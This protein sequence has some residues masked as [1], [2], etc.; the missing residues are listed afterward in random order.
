MN[1]SSWI[2][3]Q[4]YRHWIL[5]I[6]L[7][8]LC[9]K[10]KQVQL[11]MLNNQTLCTESVQH[12]K[13]RAALL[14]GCSQI[15]DTIFWQ[16]VL[17]KFEKRKKKPSDAVARGYCPQTA[18]LQKHVP[19]KVENNWVVSVDLLFSKRNSHFFF[20]SRLHGRPS[21]LYSIG[22]EQFLVNHKVL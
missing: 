12:I 8:Y 16:I 5:H 1:L 6:W 11:L 21:Q 14:S 19:F 18:Q 7:L 15:I 20:P 2:E 10:L 22:V 3:V 13:L 17:V 4:L 9:L